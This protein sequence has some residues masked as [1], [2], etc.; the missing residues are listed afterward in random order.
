MDPASSY[1]FLVRGIQSLDVTGGF[2]PC[3]LLL[4]GDQAFPVLVSPDKQVLIAASQ[5]GGG[6][7]VVAAHENILQLP[8]FLP[9]IKNALE[10]LKPS[11]GAQVGVHK[12]MDA[13]S[14]MVLG[15]GIKVH[16]GATSGTG[17]GS[18][19]STPMTIHRPMTSWSL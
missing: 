10:W 11:P 1:A 9:L 19:A 12:S 2:C 17:L 15:R 8:Q 4:T 16:P 3:E 7:M 14:E 18:T 6:R 5:Y 13:L